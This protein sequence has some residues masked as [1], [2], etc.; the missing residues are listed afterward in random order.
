MSDVPSV[1]I[2]TTLEKDST[3]EEQPSA[4]LKN[5]KSPNI[6]PP[7]YTQF[8][9]RTNYW[10]YRQVCK[11]IA[12]QKLNYCADMSIQTCCCDP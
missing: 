5:N 10:N 2:Y 7:V 4:T 3:F 12:K 9:R 11:F 1:S 6:V 8:P